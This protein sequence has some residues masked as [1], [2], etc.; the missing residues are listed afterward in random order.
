[1]SR[2]DP[3]S[4]Y[5]YDLTN[6]PLSDYRPERVRVCCECSAPAT[7]SLNGG[8]YCDAHYYEQSAVVMGLFLQQRDDERAGK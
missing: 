7:H 1:M 6:R 2:L 8:R 4:D 5:Q 3:D